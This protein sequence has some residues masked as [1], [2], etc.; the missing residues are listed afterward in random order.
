[1]SKLSTLDPSLDVVLELLF[2]SRPESNE[3][4]ITLLAAVLRPKEAF[5]KL[6]LDQERRRR[7]PTRKCRA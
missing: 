2:T 5:R 3:L 1:V 6:A 4:L 7:S